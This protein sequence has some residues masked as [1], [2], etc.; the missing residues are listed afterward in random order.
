MYIV[1]GGNKEVRASP[2]CKQLRK[3][4]AW[5]KKYLEKKG[6]PWVSYFEK[7]KGPRPKTRHHIWQTEQLGQ[8]HRISTSATYWQNKSNGN[9]GLS[10]LWGLLGDSS[11]HD[12][13]M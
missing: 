11:P 10:N 6:R 5:M 9:N 3:Q 7:G 13:S 1:D 4:K 12:Q 8:V 2:E